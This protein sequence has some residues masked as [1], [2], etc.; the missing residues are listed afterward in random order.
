[1]F[2]GILLA[3][4]QFCLAGHSTTHPTKRPQAV[5]KWCSYDTFASSITTVTLVDEILIALTLSL[6]VLLR[7]TNRRFRNSFD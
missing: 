1:M 7:L 2:K 3:S 6:I 4:L 5:T